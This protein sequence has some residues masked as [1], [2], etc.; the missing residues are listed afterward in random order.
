MVL[1][2]GQRQVLQQ[3]Y[4]A[5]P[6]RWGDLTEWERKIA[7]D[8]WQ[9]KF[10]GL[11]DDENPLWRLSSYDTDEAARQHGWTAEE[12]ARFEEVL[13]NDPGNGSEFIIVETPRAPKPWPKY[14]DIVVIG[15][16]TIEM[17]AKELAE[18]VDTLGLDPD[19]V[20]VYERENANRP[21]VI[22]AFKALK[23]KVEPEEELVQA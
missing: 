18:T 1:Q 4:S 16:R 11:T 22:E 19:A 7:L 14:D 13:R 9:D 5:G 23:N 10:R 21:E 20:I 3:G 12:K 6:F 8:H 15:R 2:D 17:V